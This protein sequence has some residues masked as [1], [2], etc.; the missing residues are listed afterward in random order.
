MIEIAK[1]EKMVQAEVAADKWWHDMSDREKK[2]YLAAHPKSKYAKN[3]DGARGGSVRRDHEN[4]A[5]SHYAA[6]KKHKKQA[7][8]HGKQVSA[9]GKRNRGSEDGAFIDHSKAKKA[10]EEAARQHLNASHSH[11]DSTVYSD[12]RK[13]AAARSAKAKSASKVADAATKKT[14]TA[15]GAKSR[16]SS[17]IDPAEIAQRPDMY[18]AA[19]LRKALKH[20]KATESQKSRIRRYI[21]A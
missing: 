9:L 10:H 8:F 14:G 2:A 12:E 20:P 4:S 5:D 21:G 7:E 19:D 13:R 15:P 1:L 17:K 6:Y 11:L 18:G 16:G 3:G